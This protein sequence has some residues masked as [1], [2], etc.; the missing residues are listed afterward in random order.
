MAATGKVPQGGFSSL[1]PCGKVDEVLT[2]F[3]HRVMPDRSRSKR[4]SLRLSVSF[5]LHHA[6]SVVVMVSNL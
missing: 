2:D 6:V 5:A 1:F 4:D 3:K